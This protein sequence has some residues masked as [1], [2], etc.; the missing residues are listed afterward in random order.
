[1]CWYSWRETVEITENLLFIWA[2][3]SS[4]KAV[5]WHLLLYANIAPATS[6]SAHM[7][8]MSMLSKLLKYSLKMKFSG[9]VTQS[10]K[11]KSYWVI[12]SFIQG[13]LSSSTQSCEFYLILILRL[14][15]ASLRVWVRSA[16]F[17]TS[18]PSFMCDPTP[19]LNSVII[20]HGNAPLAHPSL[21]RRL[22]GTQI[23]P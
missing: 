19:S 2:P 1:M 10:T 23:P 3:F 12:P 14:G 6:K 16:S 9:H 20:V 22:R 5:E 13:I 21:T 15:G 18:T 11:T 7:L 4:F 8:F 17:R